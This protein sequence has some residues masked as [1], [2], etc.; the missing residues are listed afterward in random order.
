MENVGKDL[1]LELIDIQ[2]Y[3][4]LKT[5]FETIGIPEIFNYLETII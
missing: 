1:Q 4:N 5:K 3:Y 2:C